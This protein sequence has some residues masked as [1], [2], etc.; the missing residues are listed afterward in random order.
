MDIL[1]RAGQPEPDACTEEFDTCPH[2]HWTKYNALVFFIGMKDSLGPDGKFYL[3]PMT[4]FERANYFIRAQTGLTNM[5]WVVE[6]CVLGALNCSRIRRRALHFVSYIQSYD[7]LKSFGE[8]WG[9]SVSPD[10]IRGDNRNTL[11][12]NPRN[13]LR[14]FARELYNES[15]PIINSTFGW[16]KNHGI[17]CASAL[18]LAAIVLNDAGTEL[19]RVP[20]IGGLFGINNLPGLL[21]DGLYPEPEC[22]PIRWMIKITA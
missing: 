13:K 3:V 19:E 11:T 16:K 17:I 5:N 20:Y 7:L 21:F 2:A 15:D 6:N 12:C 9:G 1:A 8:H 14:R 22:S 18:G 10:Y 4:D